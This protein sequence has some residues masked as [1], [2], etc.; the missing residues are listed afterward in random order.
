MR[1]HFIDSRGAWPFPAI[2][3]ARHDDRLEGTCTWVAISEEHANELLE[4]LPPIYIP[5]GFMVGEEASHTADGE[6]IYCAVFHL[7]GPD[8]VAREMPRSEGETAY[9]SLTALTLAR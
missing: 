3:N 1:H 4:A 8:Y 7:G 9:D 2:T 6:P 5:G